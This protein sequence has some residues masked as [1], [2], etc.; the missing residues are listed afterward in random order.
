MA[1]L[2]PTAQA[3]LAAIA[4]TACRSLAWGAGCSSDHEP[5]PRSRPGAATV[6]PH[7]ETSSIVC[8]ATF[9]NGGGLHACGFEADFSKQAKEHDNP[10][11]AMVRNIPPKLRI[12]SEGGRA[13]WCQVCSN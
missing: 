5:Q 9:G 13:L 1:P 12:Q 8:A 7:Q 4:Q 6:G 11:M 3:L 10:A 2:S